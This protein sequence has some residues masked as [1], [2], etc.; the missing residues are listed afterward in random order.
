MSDKDQKSA[1]IRMAR[2]M[3]GIEVCVGSEDFRVAKILEAEKIVE[4]GP[5]RG[6]GMKWHRVTVIEKNSETENDE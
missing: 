4:I 2:F 6:P 3:D 5:P 1:M